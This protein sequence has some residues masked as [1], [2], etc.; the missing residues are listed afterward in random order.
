MKK[1]DLRTLIFL[2]MCCDLGLFS[3]RLVAPLAN[4]VCDSLHIPGGVGTSFSLMFLVVA[5]ALASGFGCATVMGAV[6]SVLALAFGM[7][8]S[9][10]A[11][12][13]VGYI[14]PGAVIDLLLAATGRLEDRPRLMLVNSLAAVSASLTANA[15]V[16]RLSGV[17]LLLYVCVS[18]SSGALCG[19]LG[20]GLV[21]RLRP[22]LGR[23]LRRQEGRA[24]A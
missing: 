18:A 15:I 21:R 8:G 17:P 24:G 14:L 6:Q 23:S 13:F 9:M 12:S 5:A 19:M 20:A 4:L 16:F 22:V 1:F 7:V 11:L 3:K 2:A 10:G